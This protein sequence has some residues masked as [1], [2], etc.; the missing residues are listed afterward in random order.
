MSEKLQVYLQMLRSTGSKPK[1]RCDAGLTRQELHR[2]RDDSD[3]ADAEEEAYE[4]FC[5]EQVED[6]I[7]RR[8]VDGVTKTVYWNGLAIGEETVYSDK[9]LALMAR[10]HVDRYRERVEVT[11]VGTPAP[12]GL[13]DLSPESQEQLRQVLEREAASREAS[14]GGASPRRGKAGAGEEEEE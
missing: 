3:F 10:A 14:A 8:A 1:A 6:P 4:L 11:N 9:L 2:A 13:E 7:R 5:F 12:L